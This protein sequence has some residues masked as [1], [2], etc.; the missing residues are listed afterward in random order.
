MLLRVIHRLEALLGDLDI[1]CFASHLEYVKD[2]NSGEEC[3]RKR[4]GRSV[5]KF[6]RLSTEEQSLVAAAWSCL[7]GRIWVAKRCVD[8]IQE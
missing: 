3:A 5:R 8:P 7:A 1:H 2:G 4:D 6:A